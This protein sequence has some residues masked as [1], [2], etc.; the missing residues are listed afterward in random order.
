MAQPPRLEELLLDCEQAI[1][2]FVTSC[3]NDR[4]TVLS[5]NKTFDAI[6]GTIQNIRRWRVLAGV[7]MPDHVPFVI[8]PAEDRGLAISDF[9]TGF[10]RLLRQALPKQTWEW[11]RGCF[12]RLLRS[13]ENLQNKWLYIERNPVRVGL[14]QNVGAWPYYLGS[15]REQNAVGEAVSFPNRKAG[16]LTGSPTEEVA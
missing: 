3:V 11:Q 1:V 7:V 9:S 2:Y 5:N 6:R 12:D 4:R 10:K 15:I 13:D 14:V 16:N 8:T